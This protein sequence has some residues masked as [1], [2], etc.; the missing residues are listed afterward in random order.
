M[1]MIPNCEAASGSSVA[2]RI[3]LVILKELNLGNL[4]N[5]YCKSSILEKVEW[6]SLWG[7]L[8]IKIKPDIMVKLDSIGPSCLAI[9]YNGAFTKDAG[10]A[11]GYTKMGCK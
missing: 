6:C 8:K 4:G 9:L 3:N 11:E 2:L 1:L 10:E 7:C 5:I